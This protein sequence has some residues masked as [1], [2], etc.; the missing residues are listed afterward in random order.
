[1]LARNSVSRYDIAARAIREIAPEK[2]A[3]YLA[4]KEELLEYAREHSVD[5]P[6]IEE[7]GYLTLTE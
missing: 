7:W 3:E 6:E 1:M 4:R 5:S 2:A